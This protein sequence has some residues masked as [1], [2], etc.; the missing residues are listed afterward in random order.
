MEVVR[1]ADAVQAGDGAYDNDVPPAG[2]KGRCRAHAQFVYLVVDGEVLFYIGIGYR[3][4]GLR[5]VIIVVGDEILYGVVR[6]KGL[7]FAVE[8][9]CERFVVAEYQSGP[10]EALN[11]VCHSESFAAAGDSKE[12]YV[13]NSLTQSVTQAVNCFRLVPGGLV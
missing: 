9:R 10:L 13:R 1:V 2:H 3:D 6:E 8:L 4:V 12:G 7:E 5:L 11:D